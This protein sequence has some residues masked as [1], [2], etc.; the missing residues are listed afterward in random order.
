MTD[1]PRK[2][3]RDFH[4]RVLELFDGYVHGQLSKRDFIRRAGQFAAAGVT[5]AMLLDQLKPDYALAEQVS[6]YDM[7]IETNR[8]EYESPNGHGTIKALMASPAQPKGKLPAVLV[9]HENRGLNLYIED[10]ARRAAKAGF[11]ALAPDGLSAL[12]GYPGNDDEGRKMQASLDQD[13]L[14]QDFFAGFEVLRDFDGS[15][16]RVGAVGF[17]YGGGVCN[18]LAVEYRDLGC[19]VPFYGRPADTADVPKI[20]APLMLH[21]AEKDPRIN[22]AWPAYEAAL[23]ANGKSYEAHFYPGTSHGFHNDTTP[24][25]DSRAAQLAW[26]RTIG[27]FGTHLKA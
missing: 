26:D 22:A 1:E 13:K 8:V 7:A 16:G 18:R 5:G 19:A 15:T 27:F 10:V 6:P 4:P 11:I 23:K 17:C 9:I 20:R 25:F 12:G 14:L 3:I 24:R 21:F 2:T